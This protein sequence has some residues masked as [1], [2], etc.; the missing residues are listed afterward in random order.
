MILCNTSHKI[1]VSHLVFILYAY[2][3]SPCQLKKC[4]RIFKKGEKRVQSI[5]EGLP[6]LKKSGPDGGGC[7]TRATL[8]F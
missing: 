8:K 4:A 7:T 3:G 5:Q 6:L 2:R 1:Y